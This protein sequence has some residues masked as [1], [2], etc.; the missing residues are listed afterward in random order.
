MLNPPSD[1]RYELVLRA[2]NK[3]T[4]ARETL[5]AS[6]HDA[7]DLIAQCEKVAFQKTKTRSSK[8][9]LKVKSK[10]LPHFL[11]AENKTKK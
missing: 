1:E 8:K 10:V 11:E 7:L 3:R 4:P 9:N 6:R 5:K 2:E